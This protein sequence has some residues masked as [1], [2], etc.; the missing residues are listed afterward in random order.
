M[1]EV[2][3]PRSMNANATSAG[4]QKHR[5]GNP[6]NIDAYIV[7]TIGGLI[8]IFPFVWQIIM[9][10]STQSEV[11]SVPPSLWPDKAQWSNFAD[12]F[13]AVPF[14]S[15]FL[16]SVGVTIIRVL[17]QLIL[18]A[19]AG[20]A[21]ARLHFRGR[22]IVFGV[23][24]SILMVPNQIYLI[25]QYQIVQSMGWLNTVWGIAAPGVFSALG[26]FLMRQAFLGLPDELEEA[27]RLDGANVWQIFRRVLLP[28]VGPTLSSVAILTA[29]ASWN[30]LMWPL[31]VS[32][33]DESMPLAAGIVTLQGQFTTNYPVLMAASLM[34]MAPLIIL[35]LVL[36]RR[37]VEGLAHQ[38]MKG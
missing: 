13:D 26:T 20:Y 34:A 9:S 18:C 27:A 17:G 16:V 32:T 24:L 36:Q 29:L 1:S 35:F 23:L 3:T 28:L 31:V 7:L 4:G 38:G 10:L 37:V 19:M 8:M 11:T 5:P 33:Y 15:Q 2:L 14:G 25:P 21:F 22:G 6:R 12:V 30:D